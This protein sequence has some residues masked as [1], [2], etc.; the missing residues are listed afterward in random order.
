MQDLYKESW[1]LYKHHT[2]NFLDDLEYY[3]SFC[4][5]KTSLELFAGF[6]RITNKL[7]KDGIDLETIELSPEFSNSI[8]L[9]ASKKHIG[10]VTKIVLPR[11]FDRIFAAYNSFCLLTEDHQLYSFFDN[12]S[13][14][15]ADDGLISLS[16]YHPDYWDDAV[17]LQ[18]TIDGVVVD[19]EPSFDLSKSNEKKALWKDKYLFQGKVVQ[20]EYPV[21]IFDEHDLRKFVEK[22]NLKIVDKVL[23]FN[24]SNI[25]EP[26]WI[27]YIISF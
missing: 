2:E 4:F 18:L 27:D 9:P 21:R 5:G 16:Y 11:K 1:R 20:H 8:M 15:L 10:D 23:N 19:Y 17:P 26:G 13:K 7:S 3:R 12:I 6:G 24:N 25:S 22:S 14:M